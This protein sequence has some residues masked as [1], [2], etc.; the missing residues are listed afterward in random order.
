MSSPVAGLMN[1]SLEL[2]GA[3]G[4]FYS[5]FNQDKR[6]SMCKALFNAYYQEHTN[7]AV[8]FDTNRIWTA[9]MH[10][11]NELYPQSKMICC[12]R[13]PAWVVDSFESIYRKKPFDYSKLYNPQS[14]QTVYSRTEAMMSM[15][16]VV[17]SAWTA[18]KEA[19]YG[20]FSDKLLL[21]DYDILTQYPK[22]TL[23]FIYDFLEHPQYDH[24]FQNVV[25]EENEF[26]LNLGVKDLHT[27]KRSVEFKPRRTVL[28]PELFQ[29]YSEMAFWL[30][31]S[32]TNASIIAKKEQ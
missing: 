25:Y 28:P 15:N 24:D 20:E 9:R 14:R 6:L 27:V 29:Q 17:G 16:G 5:F 8:I 13:N 7:K 12:V 30:D 31:N 3:G 21:V 19:Y 26:D 18:L 10:Q 1:A 4:E 11:L 23:S 22:R 2:M 32:A